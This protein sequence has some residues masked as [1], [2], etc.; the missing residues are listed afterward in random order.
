MKRTARECILLTATSENLVQQQRPSAAVNKSILKKK[1]E[2]VGVE[3]KARF[4]SLL[5]VVAQNF[6]PCEALV[7]M[8]HKGDSSF[9]D[10]QRHKFT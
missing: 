2:R 8:C 3:F 9:K 7:R 1:R 4:C 6:F 10:I 5:G